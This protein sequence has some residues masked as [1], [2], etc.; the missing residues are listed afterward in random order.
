MQAE[1]V[2]L[3]PAAVAGQQAQTPHFVARHHRSYGKHVVEFVRRKPLGAVGGLIVLLLIFVAL[4][5][6]WLAPY[7]YDKAVASMRLQGPSLAH[8]FGTDANGRDMLSRIIWG[9]RISVTVGFGA[10]LITTVLATSIGVVSGYMGGVFDL[11]FQRLVDIWISFPALVLLVSLVAIFGPG[12][13]SVTIILGILVTPGSSRVIRSA[14]IGMRHLPYVETA[15]CLGAGHARIIR[16]HVLPNVFVPILIPA[17]VR[18]G[19]A[20]LAEAIISLLGYGVPPPYPAWGAMLSGTGRAYMLQ[21]P[22]LSI[23]PGLAISLVVFG[24]NV[25]GDALRDVLDPRL[26]VRRRDRSARSCRL[27][28]SLRERIYNGHEG[29]TGKSISPHHGSRFEVRLR[30]P[31]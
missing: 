1:R 30:I 6:P 7:P 21:S 2:V 22:W 25:L 23:W 19:T 29:L 17:T 20:I 15:S 28:D 26:R 10:V 18:L 31:W 11:L 27:L 14:V 5:A 9:A 12:L 3:G 13:W 24:F 4:A 16:W 8:P